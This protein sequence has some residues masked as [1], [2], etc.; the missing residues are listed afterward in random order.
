MPTNERELRNDL[1]IQDIAKPKKLIG[2]KLL[3]I[4]QVSNDTGTIE[5]MVPGTGTATVNRVPGSVVTATN[6]LTTPVLF[7]CGEVSDRQAVDDSQKK[8]YGGDV[9]K[10][11]LALARTAAAIVARKS[12][13][14]IRDALLAVTA[15]PTTLANLYKTLMLTRMYI[16][17]TY[18]KPMLGVGGEGI[19]LL[20]NDATVR[21]AMKNVGVPLT[22]NPQFISNETLAVALG[23]EAVHEGNGNIWPSNHFFLVAPSDPAMD[24]KSDIQAGRTICY[25][26]NDGT[27]ETGMSALTGYDPGIKSNFVDV[28]HFLTPKVL[29]ATAIA[30]VQISDGVTNLTVTL[31]PQGAIDAG[32][33]WRPVG[34]STWKSSGDTLALPLGANEIEFKTT[35]GYTDPANLSLLIGW[36]A[37]TNTTTYVAS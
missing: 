33:K 34:T 28:E 25:V 6:N 15:T 32:A 5:S 9:P 1:L 7:S 17:N 37:Q 19:E 30:H 20:R 31:A 8:K 10:A 23:V 4:L 14:A 18:D 13:E 16:M 21:D 36:S 3:P 11:Q 22:V 2:T 27:D 29:N 35:T 26:P 12:E 24:P